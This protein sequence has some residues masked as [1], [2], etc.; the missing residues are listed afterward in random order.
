MARRRESDFGLL[1][2][3][4]GIIIGV[5]TFIVSGIQSL[6][7]LRFESG[8]IISVVAVFLGILGMAGAG[9]TSRDRLIGGVVMIV[10]ALLGFEIVGGFYIISSIILLIA[11]II[12]LIEH[13]R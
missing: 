6:L 10:V 13:F 8:L 7:H 5:L 12:A 1:G 9:V 2:G 3:L 4:I 11:G